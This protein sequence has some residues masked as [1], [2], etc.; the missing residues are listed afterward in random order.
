MIMTQPTT[1]V[2]TMTT[3]PQSAPGAAYWHGFSLYQQRRPIT[4]CDNVA[5]ARGWLYG[6]YAED[7]ALAAE[8]GCKPVVTP[9]S[10]YTDDEVMA[11]VDAAEHEDMM[12]EQEAVRH[13][14]F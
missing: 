6:R 1:T 11:L 7:C 2:N 10:Q 8:F 12:A 13:G 3:N 4:W 5:Q 9:P 14:L